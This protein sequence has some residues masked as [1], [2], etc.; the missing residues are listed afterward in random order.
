MI[1]KILNNIF[2]LKV[3]FKYGVGFNFGIS[4]TGIRT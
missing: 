2:S 3:E 4:Y 1:D